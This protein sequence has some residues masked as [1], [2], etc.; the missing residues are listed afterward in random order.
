[1]PLSRVGIRLSLGGPFS[2]SPSLCLPSG[3]DVNSVAEDYCPCLV[4]YVTCEKPPQRL[5]GGE[6]ENLSVRTVAGVGLANLVDVGWGAQRDVPTTYND[7]H[8]KGRYGAQR[9]TA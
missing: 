2:D 4:D 3:K 6:A 9:P 5:S 7:D 8:G 1:M